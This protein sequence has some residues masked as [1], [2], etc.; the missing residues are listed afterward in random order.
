[1]PDLAKDGGSLS[2]K[3]FA[4]SVPALVYRADVSVAGCDCEGAEL[5]WSDDYDASVML[6]GTSIMWVVYNIPAQRGR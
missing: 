1:M 2:Q 5:I 3:P 4:P 6:G